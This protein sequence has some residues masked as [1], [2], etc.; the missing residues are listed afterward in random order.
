M[1]YPSHRPCDDLLLHGRAPAPEPPLR[2][3]N[4]GQQGP[5]A[6]AVSSSRSIH[7]RILLPPPLLLLALLLLHVPTAGGH[8][9][10]VYDIPQ[11]GE[12]RPGLQLALKKYYSRLFSIPNLAR[13]PDLVTWLPQINQPERYGTWPEV[14]PN[15]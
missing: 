9:L 11:L 3:K 1:I 13:A 12:R 6:G 15:P 10:G 5:G 7:P 2:A 4:C 8:D 14:D